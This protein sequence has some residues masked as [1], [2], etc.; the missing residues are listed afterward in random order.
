MIDF[1]LNIRLKDLK[2]AGFFQRNQEY[3]NYTKASPN[4][5]SPE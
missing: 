2:I 5:I 3:D 4:Y 1:D